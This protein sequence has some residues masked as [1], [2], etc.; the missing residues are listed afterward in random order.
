MSH[1]VETRDCIQIPR[2][3]RYEKVEKWVPCTYLVFSLWFPRNVTDSVWALKYEFLASLMDIWQ[4]L[5]VMY[6]ESRPSIKTWKGKCKKTRN[7]LNLDYN[8]PG[9][10]CECAPSL[11]SQRPRLPCCWSDYWWYIQVFSKFISQWN[12]LEHWRSWDCLCL[13]AS[14]WKK[15]LI[16]ILPSSKVFSFFPSLLTKSK[17]K[18]TSISRVRPGVRRFWRHVSV[19]DSSKPGEED[20][21][22][23]TKHLILRLR[24][25]YLLV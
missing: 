8:Q 21:S 7:C 17:N 9:N 20:H 18:A 12:T 3:N 6:G 5:W 4:N 19:V 10:M 15:K 22:T 1:I 16:N 23:I 14:P 24:L 2:R 11:L 25:G 13:E